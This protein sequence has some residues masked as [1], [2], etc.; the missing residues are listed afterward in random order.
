MDSLLAPRTGLPTATRPPGRI[1][2][3]LRRNSLFLLMLL[4]GTLLIVL[5]YYVPYYGLA[6]AFEDFSI[7]KGVFH[8]P[9]IW[10]RNFTDFFGSV[11]FFRI[12]RNTFLLSFFSMLFSFPAPIAFAL[13]LNEV[14]HS[15]YKRTLQTISYLPHF[16]STVILVGF[17]YTLFSP[18]QGIVTLLVQGIVGHKV[19]FLGTSTWFRPIYIGLGIYSSFGWDSIIFLAALSG[20]DPTLYEAARID[21]ANRWQQMRRVTLPS[22]MPTIVILLILRVGSLLDV[23]FET[24]YLLSNAAIYDVADVIS[25][26]VFRKGVIEMDYGYSTAVGIFNSVVNFGFVWIANAISRKVNDI[27][28]W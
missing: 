27:S 6:M 2:R 9:W 18:S 12:L 3:Y 24:V 17:V 22:I 19:A 1:G 8:S 14:R 10:F 11:Y 16:L 25:T 5:F 28:L 20:I 15:L 4:P 7:G 23:G 21:G 26:Y 13:L